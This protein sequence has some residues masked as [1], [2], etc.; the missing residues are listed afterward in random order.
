MPPALG[1]MTTCG[2]HSSLVAWLRVLFVSLTVCHNRL[3]KLKLAIYMSD[4]FLSHVL[5]HSTSQSSSKPFLT[6]TSHTSS[7]ATEWSSFILHCFSISVESHTRRCKVLRG[8]ESRGKRNI[9]FNFFFSRTKWH[10]GKHDDASLSDGRYGLLDISRFVYNTLFSTLFFWGTGEPS[11]VLPQR[12]WR[13]HSHRPT[14]RRW[15]LS[16]KWVQYWFTGLLFSKPSKLTR[17]FHSGHCM[18]LCSRRLFMA[19]MYVFQKWH[20]GTPEA[21]G[22]HVC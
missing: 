20:S 4:L 8:L 16:S 21:P 19:S 2:Q 15:I 10:D 17:A 11:E 6:E 5:H 13:T 22:P 12:I 3:S 18:R 9:L 14:K 7:G 1:G